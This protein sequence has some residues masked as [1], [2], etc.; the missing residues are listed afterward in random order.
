MAQIKLN[1]KLLLMGNLLL[2]EPTG[3]NT[4]PKFWQI[5]QLAHLVGNKSTKA[6][7]I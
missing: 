4:N 6:G 1:G 7:G 5:A 3:L 2:K